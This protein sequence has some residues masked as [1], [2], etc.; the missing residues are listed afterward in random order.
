MV[1]ADDAAALGLPPGA[2]QRGA[3]GKIAQIGGGDV[4]V[5]N[6]IDGGGKFEQAF[7]TG[8]AETVGTVYNAGLA[9]QRN[10]GRIDQ[11]E[12]LLQ[13]S[14]S[15]LGAMLSQK[16]GEWGINTEGLSEIQS[17]QA[18][19]NSL[20]P[21]Q[22]QPGSG[23]MSDADLELF[24]QSLPR[25]IN[26][27]GGNKV[28]ID[29][30]RAIAQYDAEGADIVQRMRL[31]D[32]DPD[33]LTRAEA[34]AALQSR[35]NPLAKAGG[36]SLPTVATP[37]MTTEPP[38]L[39][40]APPAAADASVSSPVDGAQSA[41]PATFKSSQKIQSTADAYGITVDELWQN[42]SPTARAKFGG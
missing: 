31:P 16:A 12:S 32:G 20:V 27:P 23:P 30:M 33:R 11:L 39:P 9:A 18:L 3:D 13:A 34:F 42:M 2:Y 37:A 24:K 19:I 40:V 35:Q 15:G 4:T 17:A 28:I 6:T 36:E 7:A 22:R 29:T 41:P 21:E 1:S 8:D 25:I 10:L 38:T 5:N 14:P 26:Q